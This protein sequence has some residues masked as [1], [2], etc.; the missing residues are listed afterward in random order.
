[1]IWQRVA[2]SLYFNPPAPRG[3][4][5]NGNLHRTTPILI[6]IHPPLAGRDGV[7]DKDGMHPISAISIHPPLAGRDGYPRRR[8][9]L[10]VIFQSTRPSR[11]GTRW[12]E[13]GGN[14]YEISIHPPLAGRDGTRIGGVFG[15]VE[16]QSTRPS[17][18]GTC[19]TV[20]LR[21]TPHP[22]SIHPPLAGRDQ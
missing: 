13:A 2:R 8:I 6:S 11:D 18:D 4:G 10:T 21:E 19:H 15:M 1:M 9:T 16:F 12:D 5:P 20:R 17:R 14:D 22:I 3:T 7:P